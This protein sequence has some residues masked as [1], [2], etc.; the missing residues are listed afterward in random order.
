M[1]GVTFRTDEVEH[2]AAIAELA[3]ILTRHVEGASVT[4]SECRSI[5]HDYHMLAGCKGFRRKAV[6]DPRDEADIFQVESGRSDI[7]QFD[8]FIIPCVRADAQLAAGGIMGR[9][10]YFGDGES[11]ERTAHFKC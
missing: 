9:I 8:E 10:I 1:D 2:F 6:T 7:L 5:F 11:E 3:A 4:C